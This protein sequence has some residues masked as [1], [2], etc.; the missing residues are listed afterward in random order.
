MS[1]QE[2]AAN[3]SNDSVMTEATTQPPASLFFAVH[4]SH[5]CDGC[6]ISPIIGK[7]F[8]ATDTA[9]FDLCSKC[10]AAYDGEELFD[11]TLLG[12]CENNYEPQKYNSCINY[13]IPSL[14]NQPPHP[15]HEQYS[16]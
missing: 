4:R 8:K 14:T 11:E 16:S 5:T 3:K 9:N 6:N 2:E 1:S 10:F 15:P 12:E 13:S 7:R